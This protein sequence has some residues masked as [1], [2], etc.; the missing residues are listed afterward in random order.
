MPSGRRPEPPALR[1]HLPTPRQ[2]S[3]PAPRVPLS[4]DVGSPVFDAAAVATLRANLHEL[5]AELHELAASVHDLRAEEHEQA[6]LHASGDPVVH[7][8]WAD[9]RRTAAAAERAS[10]QKERARRRSAMRLSKTA[11]TAEADRRPR[12]DGR[13]DAAGPVTGVAGPVTDGDP[14]GGEPDGVAVGSVSR[15]VH[16]RHDRTS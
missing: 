7:Q 9:L 12:N 11:V 5:A 4:W 8:L 3:R 1:L 16:F 15:V 6:L 13:V 14:I 2:P 10:A